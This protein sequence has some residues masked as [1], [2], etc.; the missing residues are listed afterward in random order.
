M[1]EIEK[2]QPMLSQSISTHAKVKREPLY[3]TSDLASLTSLTKQQVAYRLK[4]LAIKPV[5]QTSR[6]S[7]L[8]YKGKALYRGEDIKQLLQYNPSDLA[9]LTREPTQSI[10][11]G[12]LAL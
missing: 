8:G 10:A 4:K 2:L 1:K 6:L 7:E 5:R 3:S 9:L 11:S 12:D